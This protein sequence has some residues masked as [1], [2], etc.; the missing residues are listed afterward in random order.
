MFPTPPPP[1]WCEHV[2]NVSYLYANPSQGSF[3]YDMLKK[4]IKAKYYKQ[5]TTL[6]NQQPD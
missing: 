5:L 6:K 4:T 2:K 3:P 1:L